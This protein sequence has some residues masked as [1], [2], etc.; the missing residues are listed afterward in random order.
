[1]LA[2]DPHRRLPDGWRPPMPFPAWALYWNMRREPE[3]LWT[4]P[5][6]VD[7]E[8]QVVLYVAYGPAGKPASPRLLA[9]VA[10]RRKPPGR[11]MMVA[12]DS[13]AA[14]Q[15]VYAQAQHTLN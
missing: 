14:G 6:L 1:M 12:L 4:V 3:L 7:G 5:W 8:G 11:Q 2:P 9:N 10:A 13:N 15:S